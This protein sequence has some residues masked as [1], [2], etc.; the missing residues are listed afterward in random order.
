MLKVYNTFSKQKEAFY[1]LV[2][3]KV[4][5]YVCG[6][7]VYDFCHLGHARTLVAFDIIIRYLTLLGYEVK[8]VRNITDVDDKIIKR[9]QQNKEDVTEFAQRYI[10]ALHEDCECLHLLLPDEEP[11]ATIY[12]PKIIQLIQR[13]CDLGYAYVGSNGDVYYHVNQFRQYGR[14]SHRDLEGM[15]AGARIEVSEAKQDPLDFV[16]WKLAKPSEPSWDSP[17]GKGRPGWHIECSVMV[18][19]T[20]GSRI[21]I[22][23][24]GSDLIFPHHENEI[25]Q[26][27]AVTGETL[28]NFWMHVGML[29]IDKEKMSKSIG[30]TFTIREILK[31]YHPEVV[32]YFLISNH[33][34]SP[35][36]YDDQT[37][38]VASLALQR[39]YI[40][41]RGL[42]ISPSNMNSMHE[43]SEYYNKFIM[44]MDDDF[45]TPE[46]LAVLFDIA[47]EINRQKETDIQR[48][49][50]LAGL[51]VFL[52]SLL[53][54]LQEDPRKFLSSLED[55]AEEKDIA[56]LIQKRNKAREDKDWEAADRIR[57]EL[58]ARNIILE[59][60]AQCTT[61]RK[62]LL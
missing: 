46:A 4:S 23:G 24:G 38:K 21:D 28:A 3:K 12:M 59:D 10:Q 7:T 16:L 29:Q 44:A 49:T 55:T 35:L 37:L 20:L 34:R 32:R 47:K 5:L 48:A 39:L 62:G 1:S 9:A 41:L 51:L 43:H 13:L 54:I 33:Y 27:E 56:E 26:S 18:L 2:P 14:L 58:K 11:R 52:G 53:G 8:Y 50:D 60:T 15:L 61:W 30:N 36:H 45:N 42:L 57:Q 22:H 17:W 19:E 31:V 25:A 40:A 6:M